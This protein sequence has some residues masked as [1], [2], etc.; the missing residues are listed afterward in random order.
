MI[1]L[2]RER[3][4]SIQ[5]CNALPEQ[6]DLMCKGRTGW[7]KANPEIAEPTPTTDSKILSEELTEEQKAAKIAEL[8]K[9]LAEKQNAFSTE[10]SV[11]AKAPIKKEIEAIQAELDSLK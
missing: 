11:K 6:V 2:Y 4:G 7:S 10:K 5:V 1:K 3:D 8:E 9:L